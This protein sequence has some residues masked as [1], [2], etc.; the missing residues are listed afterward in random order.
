LTPEQQPPLIKLVDEILQLKE[1]DKTS[2]VSFQEK[3][4][5]ELVYKLYGLTE[6][7]SGIAEGKYTTPG[8]S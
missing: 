8:P 2:D 4:I 3:K 7:E 1:Q 5:N 6:E